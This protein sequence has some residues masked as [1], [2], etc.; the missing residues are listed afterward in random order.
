MCGL[1]ISKLEIKIVA[2]FHPS[3]G[4]LLNRLAIA[5]VLALGIA[6]CNSDSDSDSSDPGASIE[7]PTKPTGLGSEQ[8]VAVPEVSYPLPAVQYAAN[9][10]DGSLRWVIQDNPIAH[11]LEGINDVW[12]ATS[13]EY[14][15]AASGDGPSAYRDE[16]IV[17]AEAWKANMQYV[18]DVTNER[19]DEQAILAFLDDVRSKNYSVIDGYGPLTEE[20]VQHSDAY[21]DVTVPT[22]D[23]VLRDA[24]YMSNNNDGIS[25]AGSQSSELGDVVRLVDAFR[26]RSPASTNASKYIF[27]T[28]RPWR[29]TDDGSIDYLGTVS[30]QCVDANGATETRT[31]DSYN[32]NAKVVPGLMCAR[33][34]HSSGDYTK[35]LYTPD[36]ENRRKDGGYPSGHTNAG[37]LAAYA[38]AYALPQR[39]A[40]MLTRASLLGEN[41]IVAGMHSPADVIGGRVHAMIVT[42]HA[43]AQ[44]DILA[45]A[46]AAYNNAQT[47]F[48]GFAAAADMDLYSYAHREVA[49]EAGLIDGARVRTEVYNT[50]AYDDN[51]L[52]KEAYRFRMTYGFPQDPAKAGQEPI[53]PAGAEALLAT[54]QPYLSAEQRRAVLYTTSIDSGYPLLDGTNGWGRLD[55]VSAADGYAE[56]IGDVTVEM[57]AR[58]GGFSAH[59][60]WRNDISGEGMLTKTGTGQLSLGGENSFTGGVLL[61]D[62]TLEANSPA[63]FGEGDVFVEKGTLQVA[64]EGAVVVTGSFTIESGELSLQMD[65]DSTQMDVSNTLY[66]AGGSLSL[67]F[68]E[69]PVAAGAEFTLATAGAIAGEFSSVD[70]GDVS[71]DL[72]YTDSQIKAI[73][74]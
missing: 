41:R 22:T 24:N 3:E 54:R 56:F 1:V 47:V 39:Y 65:E 16:P 38:Y 29:M 37:Y 34:A 30:Y 25:F 5:V 31:V 8:S 70:A 71:V 45:E 43:L 66:I 68:G 15:S 32:T 44:P 13:D 55:L 18:L 60:W 12:Q 27:S 11:L 7:K 4:Y 9:N 48:G 64:S 49:D 72:V 57:D 67:D 21:V 61:Q 46:T 74:R 26:Q 36:T 17:N 40:E 50:S 35:G 51:E 69:L 14:Q 23:Q 62:G 73:V 59:D 53:V 52:N 42:S 28:P 19:T 6:G 63:A 33:R 58:D 10:A 20:Y 2:I